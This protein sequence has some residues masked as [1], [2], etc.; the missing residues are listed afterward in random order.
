[1]KLPWHKTLLWFIMS[2][3]LHQRN[4]E[5]APTS[6]WCGHLEDYL[7][8]PSEQYLGGRVSS[9]P[10]I[11]LRRS[12]SSLPWCCQP[13]TQTR[14][15]VSLPG[16]ISPQLKSPQHHLYFPIW[17]KNLWLLALNFL[18][19]QENCWIEKRKKKKKDRA[20]AQTQPI[21]I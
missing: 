2:M 5:L 10:Q 8:C 17:E 6:F 9:R 1:M 15:L 20:A 13:Y 12:F 16:Q 14:T 11:Q 21:I 7:V 4:E 18:I 3:V 19:K